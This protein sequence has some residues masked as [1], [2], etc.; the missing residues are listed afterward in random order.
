MSP[1]PSGVP[2][3]TQ[4][5]NRVCCWDSSGTAGHNTSTKVFDKVFDSHEVYDLLKYPLIHF[6]I[7]PFG[8]EI[9]IDGTSFT[10]V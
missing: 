6:L 10:F 7:L 2:T 1:A 9:H 4:G 3:A 8:S 5:S